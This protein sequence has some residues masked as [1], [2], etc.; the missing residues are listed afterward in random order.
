MQASKSNASIQIEWKFDLFAVSTFFLRSSLLLSSCLLSCNHV[1]V[2]LFNSS[3]S[4]RYGR[5]NLFQICL[6]PISSRIAPKSFGGYLF[7][8]FS[9][10][11]TLG[12]AQKYILKM[13]INDNERRR[14][15][16]R[17]CASA[18]IDQTDQTNHQLS[19]CRYLDEAERRWYCWKAEKQT[20]MSWKVMWFVCARD[21]KRV[22]FDD[23]DWTHIVVVQM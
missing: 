16:H 13:H 14:S 18:N 5:Q 3:M 10:D 15:H 19:D 23:A 9:V 7:I 2:E 1:F 22:V 12:F 11:I 4:N 8:T 17:S 21:W 20:E 6:S